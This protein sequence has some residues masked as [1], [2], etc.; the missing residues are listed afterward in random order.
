MQDVITWR[1]LLLGT[2]WS[3]MYKTLRLVVALTTTS[4]A[5]VGNLGSLLNVMNEWM[6]EWMNEY[7]RHNHESVESEVIEKNCAKASIHSVTN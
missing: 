2:F 4:L 3:T 5:S 7:D 6:N 1:R